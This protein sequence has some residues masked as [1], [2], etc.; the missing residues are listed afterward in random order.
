MMTYALAFLNLY[1]ISFFLG[2][3]RFISNSKWNDQHQEETSMRRRRSWNWIGDNVRLNSE[4]ER[5]FNEEHKGDGDEDGSSGS[6]DDEELIRN[7]YEKE[8]V[9]GVLIRIY[10]AILHKC[11]KQ[12]QESSMV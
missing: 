11:L 5:V 3:L 4:E 6:S 8:D 1:H 2:S 12:E 10:H 9:V 7:K